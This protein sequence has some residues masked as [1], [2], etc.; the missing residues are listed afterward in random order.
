MGM[1]PVLDSVRALY[2]KL[3]REA[4]RAIH[5]KT[6]NHKADHFFNF[7]VTAHAMRD[8]YLEEK[9]ILQNSKPA[10]VL[11]TT[12]NAEPLL[13]A[14]KEIANLSKHFQLRDRKTKA[15]TPSKTRRLVR[16]QGEMVDVNINPAGDIEL[17]PRPSPEIRLTLSDGTRHDLWEFVVDVTEFWREFLKTNGVRARRQSVSALLDS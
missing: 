4:Y 1:K 17:I 15:P 12:W 13:V 7:C 2:R 16:R 3:E 11:H 14:A 6:A 8:F 10:Q 5:A 9:G